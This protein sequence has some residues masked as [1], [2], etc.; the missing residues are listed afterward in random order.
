MRRLAL[1][2]TAGILCTAVV[3][4]GCTK[5]PAGQTMMTAVRFLRFQVSDTLDEEVLVQADAFADR[6]QELSD[7]TMVVN[8]TTAP[9]LGQ[10]E[11]AAG[12]ADLAFLRNTQMA[13]A[14]S[15]FAM[16]SLPFMYDSY[17][18]MSIALN[19]EELR[20]ILCANM[21]VRGLVP[22]MAAVDSSAVLVSSAGEPRVAADFRDLVIAMR[23]GNTDKLMMFAALGA[24][25][26]PYSQTS[27]VSFL[28][29]EL[30]I[31]SDGQTQP[32]TDIVVDTVELDLNQVPDMNFEEENLYLINTYHT[33]EPLWL[34]MNAQV[35]ETL[36]DRER[37][38]LYEASAG[39]LAGLDRRREAHEK[40]LYE[41][42][43]ER[44]VSAVE[45]ERPEIGLSLYGTDKNTPAYFDRALYRMIQ[46]YS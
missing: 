14:D 27:L 13:Q 18:H 11:L 19:S 8:V 16:F 42:L 25:V 44:G 31:Y 26:V 40:E 15:L 3:L 1:R 46:S 7:G 33:A 28:G 12:Q 2:I 34:V 23:T 38:V 20:K 45:V 36:T 43:E 9:A 32:S 21:S 39:L 37:A 41:Q 30:E 24:Q 4:C 5:E 29:Q 10:S 6:V 17:S 22:L 35:F